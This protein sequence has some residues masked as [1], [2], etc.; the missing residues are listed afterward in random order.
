[1]RAAKFDG[2]EAK[3]ARPRKGRRDV[4]RR[5]LPL[6]WRAAAASSSL[7]RLPRLRLSVSQE[8][9]ERDENQSRHSLSSFLIP[10]D[11]E[12][13]FLRRS[14]ITSNF[15]PLI[16]LALLASRA[17]RAFRS[18]S[19]H[20]DVDFPSSMARPKEEELLLL[21]VTINATC[22]FICSENML[23]HCSSI[24]ELRFAIVGAI[25]CA[26]EFLDPAIHE[27][28]PILHSRL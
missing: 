27:S 18:A 7:A 20:L 9:K 6:R 23:P 3:G 10:W 4:A 13:I 8:A 12:A 26:S 11:L 17:P 5:D 19:P 25:R 22:F 28:A 1:M 16:N 24:K 21:V 14:P 2:S 15:L